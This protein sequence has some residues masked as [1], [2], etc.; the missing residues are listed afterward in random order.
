MPYTH[1]VCQNDSQLSRKSHNRI[2]NYAPSNT[3]R[4]QFEPNFGLVSLGLLLKKLSKCF[5]DIRYS[6]TVIVSR[7][8]KTHISSKCSL[9]FNIYEHSKK[10]FSLAIIS[11]YGDSDVNNNNTN[12]FNKYN[13]LVDNLSPQQIFLLK[14]KKKYIYDR[15][16]TLDPIK[17]V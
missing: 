10:Y 8:K 14:R 16:Y 6:K 12:K 11:E 17:I 13:N 15:V 7:I 5:K 4:F 2:V 3:L 1:L 9:N